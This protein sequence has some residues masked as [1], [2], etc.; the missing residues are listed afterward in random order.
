M[1][2]QLDISNVSLTL[3]EENQTL[4]LEMFSLPLDVSIFNE[5]VMRDLS[6]RVGEEEIEMVA[7]AALKKLDEILILN[8]LKERIVR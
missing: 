8:A 5:D 3:D 6:D 4:E 1:R 2:I 7:S